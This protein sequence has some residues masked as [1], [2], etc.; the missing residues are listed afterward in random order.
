LKWDMSV[1][2]DWESPPSS[3]K[4]E[5]WFPYWV[6]IR[7]K[8]K[9]SQFAPMIGR[10]A[11]LKL[12]KEAIDQGFFDKHFLLDLKENIETQLG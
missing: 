5:Y 12:L 11:L 10:N 4:N 3:D 8:E 6:K 2:I 7:G 1:Q 9:Y